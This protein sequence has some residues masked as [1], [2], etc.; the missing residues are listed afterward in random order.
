MQE[1][2]QLHGFLISKPDMEG[3][4]FLGMSDAGANTEHFFVTKNDP[5]H[6]DDPSVTE[7]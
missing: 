3:D 1:R 6:T 4:V 2:P 5:G 7:R